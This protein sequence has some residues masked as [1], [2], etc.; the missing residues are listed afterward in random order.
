MIT[1]SMNVRQAAAV[2]D[3]L[4]DELLPKI[5]NEFLLTNYRN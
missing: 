5:P 4:F 3:A 1:I 2:R